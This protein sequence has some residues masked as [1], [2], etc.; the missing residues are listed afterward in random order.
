VTS[1]VRNTVAARSGRA[2]ARRLGKVGAHHPNLPGAEVLAGR[3]A[4]L[5]PVS[6]V[7]GTLSAPSKDGAR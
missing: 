7:Q 5:P 4:V 3:S 1:F 6:R 2:G